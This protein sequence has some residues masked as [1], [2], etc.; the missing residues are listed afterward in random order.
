VI[1]NM[2]RSA[3]GQGVAGGSWSGEGDT[4]ALTGAG[5]APAQ[6]GFF[7]KLTM[8]NKFML[9]AAALSAFGGKNKSG[10]G[11]QMPQVSPER[12]EYFNRPQ[13][14]FD[15]N[16]MMADASAAGM[17]LHQFMAQNWNSISGGAYNSP[18]AR[19]AAGGALGML[20]GGGSGRDDTIPAR[21][22]DGEYVM[23]AETV[24][25][26]GDGSNK[27]GARRLDAMR[28]RLREHKGEMLARGEFSPDAKSPLAYLQGVM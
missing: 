28:E 26:L 18:V 10:G 6:K 23:D 27:E 9:G 4:A 3:A 24:A 15:W 16:R 8:P 1:D 12:Q 11:L 17:N 14:Q 21:L 5:A 7:S 22:S 19:M 2:Q 13:Q 25:L 20:V